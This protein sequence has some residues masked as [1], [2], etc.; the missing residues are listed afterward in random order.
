MCGVSHRQ[1][2]GKASAQTAKMYGI[3]HLGNTN[4][5]EGA[6]AII[7]VGGVVQ[8]QRT[9]TLRCNR[10][11]T[12]TLNHKRHGTGC[13]EGHASG[14]KGRGSTKA[15]SSVGG[16]EGR[17]A[18]HGVCTRHTPTTPQQRRWNR[19]VVAMRSGVQQATPR[20]WVNKHPVH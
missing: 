6:A 9:S 12:N 1:T 17:T 11:V 14:A 8:W 4:K 16:G 7:P 10:W 2:P 13:S 5:K 18:A 20:C 19:R 3:R 15:T